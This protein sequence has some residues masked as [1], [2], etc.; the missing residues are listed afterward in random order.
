MYL[1]TSLISLSFLGLVELVWLNH[2]P[3]YIHLVT[4]YACNQVAKMWLEKKYTLNSAPW[5]SNEPLMLPSNHIL[6][7]WPIPSSHLDDY[8]LSSPSSLLM[9]L[10]VKSINFWTLLFWMTVY[11]VFFSLALRWLLPNLMRK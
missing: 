7:P 8:F 11:L 10:R 3:T 2:N 4:V 5:N 1:Y 9:E 6:F